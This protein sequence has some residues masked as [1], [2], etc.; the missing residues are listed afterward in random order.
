[1]SRTLMLTLL[2]IAFASLAF[3]W[4]AVGMGAVSLCMLALMVPCMGLAWRKYPGAGGLA[5][6]LATIGAAAGLWRGMPLAAGLGGVMCALAA[7]DL[8]SFSRRLR[9]A[10]PQDLPGR[11]EGRHLALLAVILAVGA[12]I[13]L[14]TQVI[15]FRFNFEWAAVLAVLSFAGITALV[16]WL[17]KREN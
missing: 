6:T 5:F 15:H 16:N 7:W 12:G 11:I 4:Q 8:E 3:G 14:G 9:L 2:A 13:S 10:A 17:R 1:M